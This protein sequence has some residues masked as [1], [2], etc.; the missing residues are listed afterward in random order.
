M[1]T[2]VTPRP[3]L[4]LF[5][6]VRVVI[7]D[8]WTTIYDVPDYLIPANGPTPDTTVGAA[9]I[10][11]GLLIVNA[12]VASQLVSVRII[13][14]DD[15]VRPVMADIYVPNGDGVVV[16]VNRQVLKSGEVLQAKSALA[17]TS[18]AHFSF[19]LSQRE[20]FEVIV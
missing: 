18:I 4:N 15:V 19:I 20:Q 11:T 1:P 3:P 5:E 2:I 10:V 14:T 16:D 7:T 13:G 9:A 8:E 17:T 12:G 6:A